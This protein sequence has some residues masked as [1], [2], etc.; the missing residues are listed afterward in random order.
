MNR[1]RL[2]RL[3]LTKPLGEKGAAEQE[4][5]EPLAILPKKEDNT[6]NPIAKAAENY[7]K[8]HPLTEDEIRSSDVDDIAK[9]MAV[10]HLNGEVTD[11]CIV[12]FMRASMER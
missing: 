9:D 12:P 7:K 6:F 10:D 11:D 4:G 3:S 1:Q 8:D 2:L 5:V